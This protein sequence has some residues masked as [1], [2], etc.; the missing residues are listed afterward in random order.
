MTSG[1]DQPGVAERRQG[2]QR[3]LELANFG[4][5]IHQ[6]RRRVHI[7]SGGCENFGT[8]SMILYAQQLGMGGVGVFGNSPSAQPVQQK[9]G[10]IDPGKI[11]FGIAVSAQLIQRVQCE[12]LNPGQFDKGGREKSCECTCFCDSTVRSSR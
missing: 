8:P 7:Q 1:S 6:R 3:A 2:S 5:R 4:S 12:D 10:Q 11:L 9:L